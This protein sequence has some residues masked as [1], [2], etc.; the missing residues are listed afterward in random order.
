MT[1]GSSL[2]RKEIIKC[3]KRNLEHLEGWKTM[4]RAKIWVNIIDF[5]SVLEFSKHCLMWSS[6]YI[7]EIFKTIVCGGGQ[8]EVKCL[9]FTQT[10]KL[11]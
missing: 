9:Y 11:W 7:E 6:T 5:P 1:M 4:E 2:N 8:R 10:G 3:K